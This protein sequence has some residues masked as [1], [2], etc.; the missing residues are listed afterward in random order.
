LGVGA[1]GGLLGAAFAAKGYA[2]TLVDRGSR[3]SDLRRKGLRVIAPDGNAAVT[4]NV[5]V[6]DP[7]TVHGN[8][9]IVFLA[10]KAHQISEL[11]PTLER[12]VGPDTSLVTL[13]NG[14]PWWYFQG[15]DG[16]HKGTTLQSLDPDG[17]ITSAVRPEQ[18]IGAVVYPAAELRDDGTVRH[19]EG[20]RFVLGDLDGNANGRAGRIADLISETGFRGQVQTDIRAEIWLKTWGSLAFNTV[21]ALTRST[22]AGICRDPVTKSLV[23]DLMLE[24]E[25]VANAVGAA[26]RVSLERRLAGAEQ[27]GEHKTS[28]LQDIEAGRQ[29]EVEA[30]IGSVLEIAQLTGV[31]MPRAQTVYALIKRLNDQIGQEQSVP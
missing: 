26:M 2:P 1:I 16:V 14:I 17:A 21:S 9:D 4:S 7:D 8:F 15:C 18:I 11:A 10:V 5:D 3:L 6:V 23:T 25:A 30:I 20:D 28:M 29:T 27:V 13:Q 12:L 31:E 22:M 19:V 24:T